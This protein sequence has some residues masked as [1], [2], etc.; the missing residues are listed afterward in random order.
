M[1]HTAK[2]NPG[3]LIDETMPYK[4]EYYLFGRHDDLTSLD[5]TE[6]LGVDRVRAPPPRSA[7]PATR[8]RPGSEPSPGSLRTPSGPMR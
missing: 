5:A 6:A 1:T 2:K 8:V 3:G 4:Y 7:M